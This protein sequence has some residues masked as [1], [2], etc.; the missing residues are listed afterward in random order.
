M[1]CPKCGFDCKDACFCP[2]CGTDLREITVAAKTDVEK[3]E[4]QDKEILS[5]DKPCYCNI[6]GQKVDLHQIV[7]VYG[8]GLRKTG[9]YAYL[10]SC[11]HISKE[12]AAELLDPIYSAHKDEKI[13]FWESTKDAFSMEMKRT[14]E[15]DPK[16]KRKE[17]IAK[18]EAEGKVYCPKCLSTEVTAHKRGFGFGR[19]VIGGAVGLDVGMLAGGLGS[20]KIVLTCMKCGYQWKPGKK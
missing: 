11:Y 10:Q 5:L 13:S 17:Q 18:L 9:A 15:N 12:Q 19:A 2:R 14:I 6:N 4:S 8:T 3:K 16:T 7:R 20:N 1:F